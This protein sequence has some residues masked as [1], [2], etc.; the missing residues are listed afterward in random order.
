M[1]LSVLSVVSCTEYVTV[2]KTEIIIPPKS[3]VQEVQWPYQDVPA[4]KRLINTNVMDY[5]T[6]LEK[7]LDI[8]RNNYVE[9][10]QWRDTLIKKQAEIKAAEEKEN[11]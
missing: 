5:I 2:V 3:L 4:G 6:D 9:F 1:Y 7:E 10:N 8:Q 11:L